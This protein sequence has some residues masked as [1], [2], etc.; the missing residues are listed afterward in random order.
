M[1]TTTNGIEETLRRVAR[2]EA[3]ELPFLTAYL[4]LR[5]QATGENPPIR[6]GE[7]VLRDRVR[8]ISRDMREHSPEYRSLSGDVERIHD[9]ME[10]ALPEVQAMAFVSSSGRDVFESV[11]LPAGIADRVTCGELPDIVPLARLADLEPALVALY[12]TNTLRLMVVRA[13]G[14]KELSGHDADPDEFGRHMAAGGALD[15]RVEERRAEFARE[16]AAVIERA[17]A[18]HA[19]TWLIVA[20]DE[21]AHPILRE[22]LSK[23]AVGLWRETVRLDIRASWEDVLELV[24]P[25]MERLR[26]EDAVVSADALMGEVGENDLG[27]AGIEDTRQALERGQGLELLVEEQASFAEG[28]LATLVRLAASTDMRIRFVD[29]HD[30]LRSV[31]GVGALLRFRID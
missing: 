18:K 10:Q 4:D 1:L 16:S 26:R 2:Q 9:A 6:T 29:G 7:I 3:G 19:P 11:E 17:I 28:E 21:V 15:G 27:V 20:A 25:V 8:E 13:G 31:G 12:D 23:Q 30:G 14:V 22:K 24:G 5:P